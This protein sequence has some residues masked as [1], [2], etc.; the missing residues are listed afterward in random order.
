MI[1]YTTIDAFYER[2]QQPLQPLQ[3]LTG[4]AGHF[5]LFRIE[6][7][8][9]PHHKQANYSRRNFFKISLIEGENRILYA[10]K[11]FAIEGT[12]LVFTN[13]MSPYLW[14]RITEKQ[15]GYI[16][17]FTE[18]FLSR[19]GEV[20]T[21]PVFQHSSLG[22]QMLSNTDVPFFRNLF[23]RMEEELIGNYIFKYDLIRNLLMEVI[24]GAQKRHPVEASAAPPSKAS[25]RIAAIFH[26]LL[27]R[28][29]P[30]DLSNQVIQFRTP[31][32]FAQQLNIHI[33]HLN[34][35][36]KQQTGQTTIQLINNR[37][38]EEAK[39]LLKTTDWTINQVAWS[40]GFDEPNHFSSF[41]KKRV[42][43]TPKSFRED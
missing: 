41:F 7:V 37:M 16:C 23:G 13:P 27:E 8:L 12:S 30:I 26:Q 2:I 9:S 1:D 25:E 18:A 40:L 43:N 38:V 21:F 24:H 34:K 3:P 6:K 35:A 22:V 39:I 28:Q 42:G 15:T 32:E 29:F 10:D 19:M 5:N 36:L 33:N 31:S 11:T 17:I 20:R 4:E 14:E